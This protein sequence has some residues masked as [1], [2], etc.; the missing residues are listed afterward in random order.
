M[1]R[2]ELLAAA[3]AATPLALA[4]GVPG[5]LAQSRADVMRFARALE[6][7]LVT[8]LA[9]RQAVGSGRLDDGFA[10]MARRFAG[11]EAEHAAA[12]RTVLE[13]LGGLE[14]PRPA[15]VRGLNRVGD[16]AEFAA[17][18]IRLEELAVAGH[19]A[20]AREL[21]DP[22]L[23]GTIAQVMAGDARQLAVLRAAAART[24]VTRAFETGRR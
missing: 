8:E 5:A 2:R 1:R 9:Y 6:L 16:Q 7:A 15:G 22:A 13:A 4:A 23:R 14:P 21:V 11:Q 18:A 10:R 17:F 12:L 19:H 24:P 20:A 3:A